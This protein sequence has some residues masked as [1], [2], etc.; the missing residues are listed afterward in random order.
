M[1][2]KIRKIRQLKDQKGF[3]LLE[4]LIAIVVFVLV[5]SA[6]ISL[7]VFSLRSFETAKQKY[8]AAKIAQEGMELLINKRDNHIFCLATS[9]AC[10]INDWQDNLIGSWQVDASESDRL[11]PERQFRL[12]DPSNFICVIK[13]GSKDGVFGYCGNPA[14]YLP[15]SF[16]REVRVESLNYESVLVKT[17]VRWQVRGADKEKIFEEV[18]FGLPGES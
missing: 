17:I 11:L 13:G 8:L 18:L 7:V 5:L 12:Y 15:G 3:F 10:P 6:L 14:D 9:E 4:T 2:R 1:F 16:T